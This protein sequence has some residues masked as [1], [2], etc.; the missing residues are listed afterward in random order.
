MP[1]GC[2][3]GPR[4]IDLHLSALRK[5]GAGIEQ[6]GGRLRCT[7]GAAL[8]GAEI[9]LTLPSVGG[10]IRAYGDTVHINQIGDIAINDYTGE[11]LAAPEG[12]SAFQLS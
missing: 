12:V 7:G 4:P 2:E 10:D 5:L 11:D 3:L 9:T 1:G 6:R 8:R